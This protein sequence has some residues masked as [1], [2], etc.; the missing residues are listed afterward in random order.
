MAAR[1]DLGSSVIATGLPFMGK[2]GHARAVALLAAAQAAL[3]GDHARQILGADG[4]LPH[5][6]LGALLAPDAGE[7]TRNCAI[8]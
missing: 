8:G 3:R 7:R 5:A 6:R 2:E 1:K 4:G